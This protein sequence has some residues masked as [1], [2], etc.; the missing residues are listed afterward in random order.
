M[1]GTRVAGAP[2][3]AG[4]RATWDVATALAAAIRPPDGRRRSAT[5][6][7][8]LTL[9]RV[10]LLTTEALAALAGR[11]SPQNV[12]ARLER[13]AEA[14]IVRRLYPPAGIASATRPPGLWHLTD[15]GLAVVALLG[16]C[17]P[18]Q[19]AG[20]VGHTEQSLRDL[21]AGLPRLLLLHDI[22]A[23]LARGGPGAPE[24]RAWE[25]PW[26]GAYRRPADPAWRQ[27]VLPARLGL[28]WRDGQG[29]IA[30]AADYVIVPAAEGL[31]VRYWEAPLRAFGE[32]CAWLETQ[33]SRDERG[34]LR[35]V[36]PPPRLVIATNG[37]PGGARALWHRIVRDAWGPYHLATG[38][39]VLSFDDWPATPLP[40]PEDEP[41]PGRLLRSIRAAPLT[42]RE[43]ICPVPALAGP[44]LAAALH[45]TPLALTL[46]ALDRALLTLTGRHPFLPLASAAIV[47]RRPVAQVRSRRDA[48]LRH[49][50]VRL[51]TAVEIRDVMPRGRVRAGGPVEDAPLRP[52]TPEE[53]WARLRRAE[54]HARAELAELTPAGIA[55]TA[56]WLGLTVAEARDWR[57][58]VGGGPDAPVGERGRLLVALDHT[59]AADA[60]FVD[61]HARAAAAAARGDDDRLAVWDGPAAAARA[62]VWP[63]GYGEYT[64][65][66]RRWAF[67]LELDRGHER[68]EAWL[69]KLGRY[70]ALR[71]SERT[72]R[73]FDEFPVILVIT[74]T[75]TAEAMIADAARRAA[76]GR[77]SSLP[78]LLTTRERAAAAPAGLLSAVWRGVDGDGRDRRFW[79]V[80]EAPGAP[81]R[82][83]AGR[84]RW[85]P[86]TGQPAT[87][88]CDADLD[89]D[90]GR[91]MRE[92]PDHP[93]GR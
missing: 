1:T 29:D 78:V 48:L 45:R 49:G 41:D 52:L 90:L 39:D 50:L 67:W 42:P 88:R 80:A 5:R 20:A 83:T 26:R 34:D 47:L 87:D 76:A 51:L 24:L 62:P 36:D 60:V 7:E 9:L 16:G 61:L 64:R 32:W 21:L 43:P 71:E 53:E 12:A 75:E 84:E 13:L 10:P 27:A 17:E 23:R 58:L 56:R 4:E 6:E 77:G 35:P 22:A 72:V 92:S 89:A 37:A 93:R 38:V 46:T 91:L 30:V 40:L 79:Q 74:T 57:G 3:R 31:P 19:M 82:G 14:G 81:F 69:A 70:H 28:V 65:G 85:Q 54:A 8:L 33:V 59:R 68:A 44:H 18:E 11:A 2:A 15:L 25:L 63:D 66:G 86:R 55:E 73:D